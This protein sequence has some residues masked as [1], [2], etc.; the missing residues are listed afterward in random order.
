[1]I[2]SLQQILTKRKVPYLCNRLL[3]S[4][5]QLVLFRQQR[6]RC[7]A[8]AII[9]GGF[10]NN[11]DFH[12]GRRQY[13]GRQNSGAINILEI[14]SAFKTGRS[15]CYAMSASGLRA[16]LSPEVGPILQADLQISE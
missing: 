3:R 10:S 6:R 12:V 8:L 1:M 13:V 7:R 11:P 15:Y 9:I 5:I 16:D 4:A 14:K 2:D